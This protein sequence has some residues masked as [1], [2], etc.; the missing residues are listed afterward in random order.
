MALSNPREGGGGKIPGVWLFLPDESEAWS[1]QAAVGTQG[2][3]VCVPS[4][5]MHLPESAALTVSY[6]VSISLDYLLIVER[7]LVS[8]SLTVV[9]HCLTFGLGGGGVA[10]TPPPDSADEIMRTIKQRS[11][12]GTFDNQDNIDILKSHRV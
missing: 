5:M 8:L 9:A 7:Q 1:A 3:A 2:H 4:P 10:A 6:Y 12:M 11:G